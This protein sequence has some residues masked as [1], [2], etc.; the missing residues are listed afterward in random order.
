[1][2]EMC[3]VIAVYGWHAKVR[4][5]QHKETPSAS[6][7]QRGSCCLGATTPF[8]IQIVARYFLYYLE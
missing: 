3:V 1:M 4:V 8:I 7:L 5:F 2:L 6:E